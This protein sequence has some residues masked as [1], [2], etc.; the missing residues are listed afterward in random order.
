MDLIPNTKAWLLAKLKSTCNDITITVQN[1]LSLTDKRKSVC[2]FFFFPHQT[3][4]NETV[5]S[6]LFCQVSFF[7]VLLFFF[8][9]RMLPYL[10]VSVDER[11][12]HGRL[13]IITSKPYTHLFF[14]FFCSSS[15]S[16]F[17]V[18]FLFFFFFSFL[19]SLTLS[20]S[21][22]SFTLTISLNFS[23]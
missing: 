18:F 19:R 10:N 11:P 3:V 23:V 14:F 20:F 8:F 17:F 1:H 6:K 12:C 9:F 7:V 13:I 22:C 16:F 5:S 21:N 2:F 4:F 15:S